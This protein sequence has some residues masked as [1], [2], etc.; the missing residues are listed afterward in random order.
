MRP[1]DTRVVWKLD[2]LG[3]SLKHLIEMVTLLQE[4]GIRF[5][6]L[7]SLASGQKSLYTGANGERPKAKPSHHCITPDTCRGAWLSRWNRC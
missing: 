2:R 4:R 6:S 3:R 7:T 5:K 1:G